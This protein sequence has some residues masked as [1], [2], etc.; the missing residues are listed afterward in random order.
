M[1]SAQDN[2]ARR[3]P[4]WRTVA[5]AI[6]ATIVS[7]VG[8]LAAVPSALDTTR[9]AVAWVGDIVDPP[10][11]RGR[12]VSEYVEVVRRATSWERPP[13]IYAPSVKY[14]TRHFAEL[15]PDKP[16]RMPPID[17]QPWM[18][19]AD[20][21]IA[22]PALAGRRITVSGNLSGTPSVVAQ[23][24]GRTLSWALTVIERGASRMAILCRVPLRSPMT[25]AH[26]DRVTIA[27]VIMGDGAIRRFDGRGLSRI[28]YMACSSAA[29]S[30]NITLVGP[31]R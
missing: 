7:T 12:V 27:G 25:F 22:G 8:M 31:R 30:M 19:V 6:A 26:G 2:P 15:D 11:S 17:A 29:H 5:A 3:R 10:S 20:V 16:H 13:T 28:S 4:T 24:D 23:A 18:S 1:P 21:V 14:F 9:D